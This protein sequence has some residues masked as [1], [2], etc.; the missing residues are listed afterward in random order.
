MSMINAALIDSFDNP[1]HFRSVPAPVAHAGQEVVQVLAVGLSHATRGIAAGKHY[2]SPKSLPALAGIDA[3]VVRP[4]GKLAFVMAPG[5]GTLAERIAVDRT[6]LIP[7]PC[8]AVPAVIAAS[9]NAAISSWVALK[10]RVNF[11]PGQ[12]VLVIGATGNAG[13]S[14]VTVAKHLGASRVIAAGRNRER[15][16]AQLARGADELVPL[17]ADGGATAAAYAKAAAEVDVVLDYVW[18]PPA[19]LAM[20]AILAARTDHTRIL[21]WVQVG[22]TGGMSITLGGHSLRHNALRISGSGFGSVVIGDADLPGLGAALSSGLV[23]VKPRIVPLVNVE[24]A[25]AHV[26]AAGERTVIVP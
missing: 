15:L 6:A 21:D 3:V 4:N 7:L 22:G 17:T 26:D 24:A 1:P 12:S 5:I 8:D 18:G 14:A 25:W 13:A 2:M 19:E 10:A 11:K 16:D 23:S 9:I 20:Q